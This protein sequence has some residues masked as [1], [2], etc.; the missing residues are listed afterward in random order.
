MALVH[1]LTV[2]DVLWAHLQVTR[3]VQSFHFQKLEDAVYCQYGYGRSLDLP[4]QAGRLIHG[5]AS[6]QPF[7]S[8]NSA[9]AF[10]ATVAFLE[11]NG[12]RLKMGDTDAANFVNRVLS[13]ASGDE[14]VSRV[15]ENHSD[16]GHHAPSVREAVEAV[17]AKYP[18]TIAALL[19]GEASAVA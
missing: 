19:H 8:G 3:E 13:S 10:V 7:K 11:M 5:L 14:F 15:E 9:V 1:Y 16:H 17:L 6:R 2:Q 18:S 4:A 12:L